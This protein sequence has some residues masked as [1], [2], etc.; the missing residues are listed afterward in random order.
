MAKDDDTFRQER[1]PI[2]PEEISG[3]PLDRE[4]TFEDVLKNRV[5]I[6]L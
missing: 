2:N 5:S 1:P 3:N 4:T 6:S